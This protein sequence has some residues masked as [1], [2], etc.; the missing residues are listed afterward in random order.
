SFNPQIYSWLPFF[1][2]IDKGYFKEQK[3]DVD[4][5][6]YGGS[7][8][9]QIP[10][11]A[12][13]DQDIAGMVTGPGFFNQSTEAFA[14]KLIASNQQSPKR[15]LDTMWVMVRQ[16]VW[17]AGKIKTLAD[18]KGLT[19]ELGPKGS[20]VYLTSTQAILQAGLSPKD[21]TTQE[22]LRAVS[23]ALPLFKNKA[24]DVI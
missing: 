6:T 20:P 19:I 7:A 12:R 14:I 9:S 16:D 15:C 21:V 22:R 8:L 5:A 18:L 3:L 11:L 2:A 4:V 17:D 10:M 13:G 24:M 23:D 1:L